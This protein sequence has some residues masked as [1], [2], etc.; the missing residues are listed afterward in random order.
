MA[1]TTNFLLPAW[2]DVINELPKLSDAS[3]NSESLELL[4]LDDEESTWELSDSAASTIV[5]DQC[6][7]QRS[8]TKSTCNTHNCLNNIFHDNDFNS[9]TPKPWKLH[10]RMQHETQRS[11]RSPK[12]PSFESTYSCTDCTTSLKSA[13]ELR[14]HVSQA[15][16]D[17]SKVLVCR[18]PH[19]IGLE[20]STL[21]I[22][23]PLAGC[24][25]CAGGKEYNTYYG[26]AQH[27]RRWHFS[28]ISQA[29]NSDHWPTIP[30]LRRWIGEIPDSEMSQKLPN[31][32]VDIS[33]DSAPL[34][35]R[36]L[37]SP[38]N[39]EA[40]R[41]KPNLVSTSFLFSALRNKAHV[42]L[43]EPPQDNPRSKLT[44]SSFLAPLDG[45]NFWSQQN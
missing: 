36:N 42:N 8:R 5:D 29:L 11:P 14:V 22:D 20:A 45:S 1:S 24:E 9:S 2:V 7:I 34:T 43:E 27:L 15:H 23:I 13:N 39:T 32:L 3:L 16:C 12:L 18:D 25:D 17:D 10:G 19:S 37:V 4:S 31:T 21:T 35:A 44:V 38:G 40:R 33:I 41:P 26:A 28:T 6:Q 30:E